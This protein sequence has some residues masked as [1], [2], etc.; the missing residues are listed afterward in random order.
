MDACEQCGRI[1]ERTAQNIRSTPPH[2]L[3]IGPHG[4]LVLLFMLE[5]ARTS[6]VW[7]YHTDHNGLTKSLGLRSAGTTVLLLNHLVIRRMIGVKSL[8]QAIGAFTITLN[9]PLI[10]ELCE[11]PGTVTVAHRPATLTKIIEQYA[12]S[13]TFGLEDDSLRVVRALLQSKNIELPMGVSSISVRE[14]A[15]LTGISAQ[16]V[17]QSL[18]ALR[19]MDYINAPEAPV[20]NHTEV[21]Y[22]VSTEV[23]LLKFLYE[24]H[25]KDNADLLAIEAN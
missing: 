7:H 8:C 2:A 18:K 12:S 16:R 1:Y 11:D 25:R 19:V 14:L 9:Y 4:K 23:M 3:E 20:P 10:N 13:R 6:G 5:H 24:T 21:G 17:R 15:A 22:A